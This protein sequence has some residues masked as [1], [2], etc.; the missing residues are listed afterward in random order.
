[1]ASGHVNRGWIWS[2]WRDASKIH[3][4]LGRVAV[5]IEVA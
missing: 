1:M 5:P 2:A 4:L 3:E